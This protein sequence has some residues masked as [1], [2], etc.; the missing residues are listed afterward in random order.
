MVESISVVAKRYM[1]RMEVRMNAA[2]G[3]PVMND[4]RETA[5]LESITVDELI[6]EAC[7]KN[8]H[9]REIMKGGPD[10]D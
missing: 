7:E 4:W 1:E 6:D 5:G 10:G 9:L 3:L 8:E 2:S